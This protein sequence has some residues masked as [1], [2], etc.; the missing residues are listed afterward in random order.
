[1][2]VPVVN[3]ELCIGCGICENKCPVVGQAAIQ[4][5]IPQNS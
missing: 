5:R 4:V 3:R 2:L 1:V